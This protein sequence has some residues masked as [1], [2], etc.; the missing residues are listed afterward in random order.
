MSACAWLALGVWA[1]VFVGVAALM[2][3]AFGK[4]SKPEHRRRAR[5]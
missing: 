3:G 4:P 2:R 5:W 1:L